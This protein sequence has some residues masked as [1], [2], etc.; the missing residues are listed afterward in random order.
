MFY[1][2][3][4]WSRP[5]PTTY[6]LR[7]L[8][9][10]ALVFR[11][12]TSLLKIGKKL[13]LKRQDFDDPCNGVRCALTQYYRAFRSEAQRHCLQTKQLLMN[14]SLCASMLLVTILKFL[15]FCNGK[16]MGTERYVSG[17][18]CWRLRRS[19]TRANEFDSAPRSSATTNRTASSRR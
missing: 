10:K 9:S 14:F 7:M 5:P 1:W 18:N 4:D 6:V 17:A 11:T 15:F 16:A 2:S 13:R 3:F 19:S 8:V 12:N